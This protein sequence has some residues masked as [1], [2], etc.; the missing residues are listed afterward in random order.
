MAYTLERK[1]QNNCLCK[2]GK[3]EKNF[4]ELLIIRKEFSK[5]ADEKLKYKIQ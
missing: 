3:T 1:L 2:P 5:T 4:K